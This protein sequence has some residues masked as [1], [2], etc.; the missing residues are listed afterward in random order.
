MFTLIASVAATVVAG[1]VAVLPA[2]PA[3]AIH[4]PPKLLNIVRHTLKKGTRRSYEQLEAAS[5]KAYERAHVPVYWTA[6]LST[7]DAADVV[8]LNMAES[9]EEWERLSTSDATAAAVHPEL[10][11]LS[12]RLATM[13]G[14]SASMLTTRRDEIT[15][16]RTD[17]DLVT[18]R[19]LRLVVFH[20]NPGREGAFMRA[21]RRAEGRIA[22]WSLYESN[23]D[24]TFVLVAPLKAAS[25]AKKT[26]AIPLRLQQLKRVYTKTEA[27][28]Y[29]VKPRMSHLPKT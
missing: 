27:G 3:R 21:A 28:V 20:V 23:E 9:Q 24:S 13:I 5:V 15:S 1:A 19:A 18:M 7:T 11:K 22:P 2:R 26:A 12:A 8:Y 10:R 4:P 17:V 29:L 25:E 14:S 6:L 16:N